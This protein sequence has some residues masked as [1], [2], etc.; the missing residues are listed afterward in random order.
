MARDVWISVPEAGEI[1]AAENEGFQRRMSGGGAWK[2]A[3]M[4]GGGASESATN[5]VAACAGWTRAAA[6]NASQNAGR[7]QRWSI[8]SIAISTGVLAS[9]RSAGSPRAVRANLPT[10]VF[11]Q[12]GFHRVDPTC[13]FRAW[14]PGPKR[15]AVGRALSCASPASTNYRRP[16]LQGVELHL[17]SW[18]SNFHFKF[19]HLQRVASESHYKCQS[20]RSRDRGQT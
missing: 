19:N 5:V 2:G 9:I 3:R 4:K 1:R 13:A 11:R 15:G 8:V 6:S 16:L 7:S 17:R 10:L 14:L 18:A 12:S 20:A